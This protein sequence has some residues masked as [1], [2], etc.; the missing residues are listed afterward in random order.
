MSK[1]LT[2]LAAAALLFIAVCN[3]DD[4]QTADLV[5]KAQRESAPSVAVVPQL[6]I[7]R[8]GYDLAHVSDLSNL[9]S[10]RVHY[11]LRWQWSPDVQ[12][13]AEH[14]D[15]WGELVREPLARRLVW[16]SGGT[17]GVTRELI[18]I[19]RYIYTGDGL[20]WTVAAA[21]GEDIFADNPML[22]A[23]LE[24]L[25]GYRGQLMETDVAVNGVPADHYAFD[26]TNPEVA[27]GLD[28]TSTAQG[29]VW[30][31][32]EFNV[33]VKFVLT[34][35]GQPPFAGAPEARTLRLTFD[36]LDINEPVQIAAPQGSRSVLPEDIPIPEG[37]TEVKV[38]SGIVAYEARQSVDELRSFYKTEMVRHSWAEVQASVSTALAFTKDGRTAQIMFDVEEDRTAVAITHDD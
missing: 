2:V 31:S 3:V 28:S 14:W 10:F 6:S 17:A 15:I 21:S 34:L 25:F 19:G 35:Q 36:L 11:T 13:S 22:S 26:N 9:E 1:N 24:L 5:T 18:Q 33:V 12:E 30:I 4:G 7:A 23:P 38:L 29:E 32:R 16:D 20:G 37:A 27:L 8:E